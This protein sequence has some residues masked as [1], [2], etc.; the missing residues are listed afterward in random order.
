MNCPKCSGTLKP[1]TID[2]IE[3]DQCSACSGIWFDIGE[4]DK[5]IASSYHNELTNVAANNA[6]QN[7]MHVA[8][9]NC[10]GSTQMVQLT[11]PKG[12]VIDKCTR[13]SGIW[14]DGGEYEQIVGQG[15]GQYIRH[16]F[17]I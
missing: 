12:V 5:I 7:E 13:C 17:R 11:T 6:G 14:L 16:L 10:K 2:Q 15:L 3:V 8:C 1:K 4:F 9:P